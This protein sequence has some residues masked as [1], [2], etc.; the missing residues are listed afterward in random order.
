MSPRKKD[1]KTDVVLKTARHI[2]TPASA[3]VHLHPTLGSSVQDIEEALPREGA[4]VAYTSFDLNQDMASPCR[5]SYGW[6]FVKVDE[7]V[8]ILTDFGN[9]PG[10]DERDLF[11]HL[12]KC[13]PEGQVEYSGKV[14]EG[15]KIL[16]DFGN[17]PGHD[18]RDLFE[19][20]K[21]CKPEGQVE[22]SG[23]HVF[24]IERTSEQK[25]FKNYNR[26]IQKQIEEFTKFVGN[27]LKKWLL[28][29]Q[30][31]ED[32]FTRTWYDLA[33]K[34]DT[35]ATAATQLNPVYLS[36]LNLLNILTDL[37]FSIS[38][39]SSVSLKP[40]LSSVLDTHQCNV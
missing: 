24:W 40:L 16:T 9:R 1:I 15:V 38:K 20:L 22:Y 28:E 2:H 3:H 7:G 11:E 25:L 29:A 34:R 36:Y 17:R 6:D 27:F 12:K 10:H 37:N 30:K 8:K 35:G 31:V 33:N 21:K 32:K 39:S 13:K 4:S 18:E 23:S 19:H 5:P 26:S 14:D